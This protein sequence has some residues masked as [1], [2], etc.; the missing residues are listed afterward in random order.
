[1]F[2]TYSLIRSISR[3]WGY[4]EKKKKSGICGENHGD[5]AIYG[6]FFSGF[7]TA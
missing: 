6:V 2:I 7:S 5:L 3:R 4:V 1:M